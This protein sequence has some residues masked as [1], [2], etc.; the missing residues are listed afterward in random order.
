[1]G[2][3]GNVGGSPRGPLG[4]A[5]AATVAS[6]VRSI[7]DSMVVEMGERWVRLRVVIRSISLWGNARSISA[8]RNPLF[9]V[10]CRV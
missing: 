2:R 6:W 10:D 4:S 1:M 9:D 5:A 7:G 8:A 3:E